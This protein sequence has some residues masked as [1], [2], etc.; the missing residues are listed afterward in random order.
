MRSIIIK[1]LHPLN[2]P[3]SITPVRFRSSYLFV[4]LGLFIILYLPLRAA[5]A[6]AAPI[7]FELPK[8]EELNK[9]KSAQISTSR[10]KLYFELFPEEAPWHVANFKYLA[11]S[12]FYKG[13]EFHI[14]I[15]GYILQAGSNRDSKE[16]YFLPAEF[17]SLKHKSG[18]LGMARAPDHLNPQRNSSGTQFHILLSNASKM[19]GLYTI[20]GE[21]IDGEDTLN[22]LRRDDKILDLKVFV[23]SE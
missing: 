17:S 5:P 18:T 19:D 22:S 14:F 10:G 23:S 16:A 21:L 4:F 7:P 8:V 13:K 3:K 9:L 20:F 2:S 11:D 6:L 1:G 15:E 12:N